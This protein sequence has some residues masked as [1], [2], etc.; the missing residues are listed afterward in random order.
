MDKVFKEV[1]Y[2]RRKMD[3]ISAHGIMLNIIT[4][5]GNTNLN[6]HEIIKI[7]NIHDAY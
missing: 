3:S 4:H 2:H 7:A 5:K 1:F 6:H